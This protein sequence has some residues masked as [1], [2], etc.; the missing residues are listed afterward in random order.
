MILLSFN[1]N[2]LIEGCVRLC[3][4]IYSVYVLQNHWCFYWTGHNQCCTNT[5]CLVNTCRYYIFRVCIVPSS[6]ED[7]HVNIAAPQIRHLSSVTFYVCVFQ[8]MYRSSWVHLSICLYPQWGTSWCVIQS[9]ATFFLYQLQ[10]QVR[11]HWEIKWTIL[12]TCERKQGLVP[13]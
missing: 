8:L 1:C 6:L 5:L 9:Q 10:T 13:I 3:N 4:Y 7:F 2:Y 12:L 11:T